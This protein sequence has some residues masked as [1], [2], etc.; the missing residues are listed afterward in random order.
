VTSKKQIIVENIKLEKFVHGGQAIGQINEGKKVLVWGGLP[1]EIVDVQITKKKSSFLEGVVVQ[2]HKAS[3]HRIEPREPLSYLSTS[4][5]Q[6]LG[7]GAENEAKQGILAET[8]ER[9]GISDIAWGDFYAAADEY[10]Y[11]NKQE[12]GFWGD[13]DGLHIAHYIRGTHG[14]QKVQGSAL[15]T[16]SINKAA[17]AVRNELNRLNIWGGDIKT[18]LLR[19]NNQKMVA[20]ALFIKKEQDMSKFILPKELKGLDIYYSNPQSPASVPSK[21]LYS[22]GD[23]KLVDTIMGK[24]IIYDVLSFFQVNIPVFSVALRDI[25]TALGN[26]ASIDMYSG[27]G[28]IGIAV[29]ADKLVESDGFSVEMAKLNAQSTNAQVIHASSETALEHITGKE[30]LIVDPPRAGLHKDV[31]HRIAEVRPPQIIYL[32]CNPS[33]QARD[34]TMLRE[35]YKIS[36]AQGY[37]FFPRTPHIES[38]IVLE[39]K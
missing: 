4:P 7:F 28:T 29:G 25:K 15:A 37:N 30:T 26:N 5:W 31:I 22:F 10:G 1:G 35:Q 36:F 39:L 32:S 18:I 3:P 23:I 13:D 6:I 34:V 17:I 14:K 11:R 12:Y 33:T 9:E 20:G 21:K 16:E 38:L 27:V 19:T 2:V 24:N 8:F